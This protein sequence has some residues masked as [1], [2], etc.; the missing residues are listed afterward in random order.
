MDDV[1]APQL[2]PSR[3]TA[4]VTG[5]TGYLGGRLVPQL[6]A[7]GHRV[8]VIAR[9]ERR[10]AEVPWRDDVEVV[11]GDLS[12]AEDTAR[13]LRPDGAGGDAAGDVDVLFYL[14]HS[15]GAS[16]DFETTELDM[17]RS[18]AR[19]ARRAGVRRI[20]YLGGLHPDG[21]ELSPHMR[22]RTA[23]GDALL[24]SGVPT[25]VYQ[26]GVVIG[27][28][29]A[30]FEMIRHLTENLPVMPAPAWVRNR[31]EP[32]AV[33]DVL[34]YLVGAVRVPLDVSRRF[35]LGSREVLSYA[36]LMYGYMHEAGL[37]KRRIYSL[38]TPAPRLAGWW[39]TLVTP[40]PHGMAVPLVQSLQH[41]AVSREHDIDEHVPLPPDGLTPYREA[42]RLALG[43]M[44]RGDVETTWAGASSGV[45]ADPLPSDPAW[46][47][48]TVYTDERER[49]ARHVDPA[50]AWRVV[51]GVAA[52]TAGT[53]CPS[54]GR[55][56]GC[57]TSSSVA[58]AAGGAAATRSGSSS[59]TRS[60]G[61]GSRRSSAATCCG[62]ARRCA[63][64]ATRGSRWSSSRPRAAARATGSGRSTSRAACGA[65]RT[66][67]R[68]G[69]STRSSSPRWRATC[70][71]RLRRATTTRGRR[72]RRDPGSQRCSR[73][74]MTSCVMR[75]PATMFS[76]RKRRHPAFARSQSSSVMLRNGATDTA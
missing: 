73:M 30:S 11:E 22:S 45:P 17:A 20:V 67:G 40:I 14:V 57:S 56:A 6:L 32:I 29:S 4:L 61:G 69:P 3:V 13:A 25:I 9:D 1:A 39:V 21:V 28:G 35:D 41:D 71:P 15:M 7:A 48:L 65:R 64:R 2:L 27:S 47:G 38:P 55:C 74:M 72:R 50:D 54:R 18:V 8:K 10:L 12:E 19:E 44:S 43:K 75:N 26:A 52:R 76:H 34:H 31:I 37:P 51:E 36:G 59:V 60:T 5:A 62:C 16:G 63:C 66:G 42:V 68:S 53:R 70:S 58:W 33:R 24:D 23:V 46:A 49:T